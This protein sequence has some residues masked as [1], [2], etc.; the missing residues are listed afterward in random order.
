MWIGKKKTAEK[1]ITFCLGSRRA[2][3]DAGAFEGCGALVRRPMESR[4]G[5]ALPRLLVILQQ[6]S[7]SAWRACR[8]ARVRSTLIPG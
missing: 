5:L 2:K 7:A 4:Q 1:T 3:S 6:L 8:A